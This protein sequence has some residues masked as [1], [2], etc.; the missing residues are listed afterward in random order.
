MNGN[1]SIFL[2]IPQLEGRREAADELLVR[3]TQTS[4][5]FAIFGGGSED[6]KALFDLPHCSNGFAAAVSALAD[7]PVFA[8]P[9]AHA[10]VAV[11]TDNLI[12]VPKALEAEDPAVY[13]RYF[14]FTDGT[15]VHQRDDQEFNTVFTIPEK[16]EHFLTHFDQATLLPL[17][18]PMLSMTRHFQGDALVLDFNPQQVSFLLKKDGLPVFFQTYE[19]ENSAELNYYLL[20][21]I[22]SLT[23]NRNTTVYLSGII[24]EDDTAHSCVSKYFDQVYFFLPA[25]PESDI[26]LLN[27]L[28]LHYYSTLLAQLSCGL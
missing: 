14:N 1:N 28:P 5:S 21:L 16:A 15:A 27:D 3:I 9:F 8:L 11:Q 19:I 10:Y 23:L 26:A 7:D 24:H 22:D 25:Q 18:T 12:F 2:S 4:F 13:A 20:L 6:L 17:A